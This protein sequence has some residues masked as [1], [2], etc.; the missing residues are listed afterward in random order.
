MDITL[1]QAEEV[2]KAAHVKAQELGIKIVAAVVESNGHIVEVKRMDGAP[3]GS[4]DVAINKAYT[5][6]AWGISTATIA[7]E[8]RPNGSLY[9]I[10]FSNNQRLITFGGGEPIYVRNKL[11]GAVGISGG[12]ADQD[13]E[14]ADAG[15]DALK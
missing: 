1:N 13:K 4:I 3:W 15:V 2:I 11:I 6:S 12:T 14:C 7:D 5:A 10:H 8:C 9:S